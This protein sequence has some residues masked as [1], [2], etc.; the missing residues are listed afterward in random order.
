MVSFSGDDN[1]LFNCVPLQALAFKQL[2]GR[3]NIAAALTDAV[4]AASEHC[5]ASAGKE[6]DEGQKTTYS[7]VLVSDGQDNC[8]TEQGLDNA[9]AAAGQR[10][11]AHG[12]QTVFTAIGF[13]DFCFVSQHSQ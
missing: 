3:T 11:R 12:M 5:R 4:N 1:P 10:L 7:L 2:E 6:E 9:I 13:T 8:N